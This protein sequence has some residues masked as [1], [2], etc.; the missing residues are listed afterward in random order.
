MLICMKWCDCCA[1]QRR[2]MQSCSACSLGVLLFQ[3]LVLQHGVNQ[4]WQAFL[5]M[6]V[7]DDREKYFI[8]CA[9]TV[10]QQNSQH[11]MNSGRGQR[12]KEFDFLG[13][14]SAPLLTICV[15]RA[16][17]WLMLYLLS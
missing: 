3:M 11:G 13:M 15:S 6:L 16:S 5:S 14:V 9:A 1:T 8:E 17:C 12:E 4:R 7:A 2:H 10:L